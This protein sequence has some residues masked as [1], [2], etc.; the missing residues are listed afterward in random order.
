V[1]TDNGRDM[2][3]AHSPIGEKSYSCGLPI[4][5]NMLFA[6]CGLIEVILA[7]L[8]PVPLYFENKQL[9]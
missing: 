2:G 8:L 1:A 3:Q 7:Y 6:M 9:N 4:F 5:S